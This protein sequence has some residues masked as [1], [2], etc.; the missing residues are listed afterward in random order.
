VLLLGFGGA[1]AAASTL[2]AADDNLLAV[3]SAVASSNDCTAFATGLGL[4]AGTAPVGYTDSL[5]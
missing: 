2:N 5:S 3:E 4:L 1:F